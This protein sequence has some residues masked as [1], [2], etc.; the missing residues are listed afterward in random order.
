MFPEHRQGGCLNYHPRQPV[1]T[2]D[3]SSGEEIF[4]NIQ[5]EHPLVQLE[6]SPSHPIVS[7]MREDTIP[8][9]VPSFWQ[10]QKMA[11]NTPFRQEDPF[12][13]VGSTCTFIQSTSKYPN[14]KQLFVLFISL[15]V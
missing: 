10:N 11:Q 9:Q 7:H 15:H 13:T 4:R 1:T 12:C 5:P 3:C 2:P 14:L 8:L 6:A